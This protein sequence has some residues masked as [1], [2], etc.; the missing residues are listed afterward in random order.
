MICHR[1]DW[2]CTDEART[3]F[4]IP[5][6]TQRSRTSGIA[7]CRH[8][9]TRVLRQGSDEL[10]AHSTLCHIASI[11]Q[12]VTLWGQC[13][14]NAGKLGLVRSKNATVDHRVAKIQRPLTTMADDVNRINAGSPL[15]VGRHLGKA[16]RCAI[17][18]EHLCRIGQTVDQ[19]LI[20]GDPGVD[21]DD[22]AGGHGDL[23]L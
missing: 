3:S 9:R 18:N 11:K 1:Y 15:Q 17:Q 2:H 16:I 6:S 22:V 7:R 20:V 8:I 21:E 10:Q 19:R 5:I 4:K 12:D 14:A 23:P 13:T